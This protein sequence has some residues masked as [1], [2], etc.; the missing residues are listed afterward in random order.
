[1]AKPKTLNPLAGWPAGAN[2]RDVAAIDR[3]LTEAYKRKDKAQGE[4]NRVWAEVKDLATTMGYQTATRLR[5][6]AEKHSKLVTQLSRIIDRWE[7][8]RE[9]LINPVQGLPLGQP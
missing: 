7:A 5:D 2:P 8:A 3:N 4:L 9:L 6:H 1:M